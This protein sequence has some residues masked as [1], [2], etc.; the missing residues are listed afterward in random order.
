MFYKQWV[1]VVFTER[2]GELGLDYNGQSRQGYFFD[3]L[4]GRLRYVP[5]QWPR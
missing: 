3:D 4:D 5:S 2:A 1:W